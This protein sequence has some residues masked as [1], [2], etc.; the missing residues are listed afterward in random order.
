MRMTM[1]RTLQGKIMGRIVGRVGIKVDGRI[2][3]DVRL[4]PY[5]GQKVFIKIDGKA[6]YIYRSDRVFLFVMY[7]DAAS[8]S[9]W[10]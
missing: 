9:F 6:L 10:R 3:S 1:R 5:T 2:Y 7:T 8:N 4:L